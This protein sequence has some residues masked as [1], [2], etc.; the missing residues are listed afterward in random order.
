[1]AWDLREK[2]TQAVLTH[3]RPAAQRAYYLLSAFPQPTST[4]PVSLCAQSP[5][6]N[7]PWRAPTASLLNLSTVTGFL[8]TLQNV[9]EWWAVVLRIGVGVGGTA[10]SP[11]P[12]ITTTDGS[13]GPGSFPPPGA[14]VFTGADTPHTPRLCAAFSPPPTLYGREHSAFWAAGTVGACSCLCVCVRALNIRP[15]AAASSPETLPAIP[16]PTTF[17]PEAQTQG[18][19]TILPTTACPR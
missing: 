15:G 18:C 2:L 8:P 12:A 6:R 14:P 5:A 1:M 17:P 9:A 16:A 13:S 3:V 11:P 10:P 4:H 7:T 19:A